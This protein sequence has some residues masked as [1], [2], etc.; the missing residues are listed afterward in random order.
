MTYT[1]CVCPGLASTRDESKSPHPRPTLEH[2]NLTHKNVL[3][4]EVKTASLVTMLSDC[5]RKKKYLKCNGEERVVLVNLT[6]KRF[7]SLEEINESLVILGPMLIL[8]HPVC[9]FPFILHK[10]PPHKWFTP[11]IGSN[12]LCV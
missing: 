12:G 10:N 4:A 3:G 2:G 1:L 8:F 9:Y 5:L 6:M 7:V 11:S